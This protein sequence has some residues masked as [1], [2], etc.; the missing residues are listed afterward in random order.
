MVLKLWRAHAIMCHVKSIATFQKVW[1]ILLT[2]SMIF[3]Y[4]LIALTA[5]VEQD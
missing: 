5:N 3:I 1:K 4:S 2:L